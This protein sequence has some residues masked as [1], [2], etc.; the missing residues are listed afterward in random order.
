MAALF[1]ATLAQI[2]ACCMV[3]EAIT[4]INVALSEGF[5]AFD[6][7]QFHRTSSWWK[8]ALM[9]SLICVWINGWINNRQAGDLKRYR[10]HYDVTLMTISRSIYGR[11]ERDDVISPSGCG[12]MS[13]LNPQ[14]TKRIS[15]IIEQFRNLAQR[16]SITIYN[17]QLR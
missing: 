1:P 10:A 16:D 15:W 8:Y 12:F 11:F 17:Y 4:W 7:K 3:Y 2:R 13:L 14:T 5:V 6:W 9:F